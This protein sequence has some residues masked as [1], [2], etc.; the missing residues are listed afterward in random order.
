MELIPEFYEYDPSFLLNRLSVF[1]TPLPSSLP[2]FP[3][4]FPSHGLPQ[5]PQQL[6]VPLGDVELPPWPPAKPRAMPAEADDYFAETEGCLETPRPPHSLKGRDRRLES[7]SGNGVGLRSEPLAFDRGEE[8][9]N[10]VGGTRRGRERGDAASFLLH[11]REALEGTWTSKNV[12]NWI[13]L[14][15]GYKQTG[16]VRVAVLLLIWWYMCTLCVGGGV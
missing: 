1:L 7:T 11:L 15:F 6:P 2:L 5:T 4:S 13:D 16:E 3:S 14:I 8:V 12:H 9:R 10:G